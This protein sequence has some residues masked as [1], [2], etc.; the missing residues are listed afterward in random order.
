MMSFPES[1]G[2]TGDNTEPLT[3]I[4]A[5]QTKIKPEDAAFRRPAQTSGANMDSNVLMTQAL[6]SIVN[7]LA[8]M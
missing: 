8:R 7:Q 3:D 4:F 5:R 6:S 2:T 1:T